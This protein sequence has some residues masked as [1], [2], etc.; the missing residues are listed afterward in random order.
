KGESRDGGTKRGGGAGRNCI[1]PV[2]RTRRMLK[3]RPTAS[4]TAAPC[5][6]MPTEPSVTIQV[7][8]RPAWL[9]GARCETAKF[10]ERFA[11]NF[12]SI[13]L[14]IRLKIAR[15]RSGRRRG[16]LLARDCGNRPGRDVKMRS[17]RLDAT[18]WRI[19]HALQA[20]GRLTNFDLSPKVGIS[21]PASP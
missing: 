14:A 9:D 17:A 6:S 16:R 4:A 18:D 21:G 3:G 2:T 13:L 1:P 19:L 8:P 11:L 5:A 12:F 20:D 10:P 7:S 15:D